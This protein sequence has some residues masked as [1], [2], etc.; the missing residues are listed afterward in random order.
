RKPH[1]PIFQHVVDHAQLKPQETVF[2]EDTPHN[3]EGAKA[4]GINPL[5]HPR[6][7]D[8]TNTIRT[9]L[10]QHNL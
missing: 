9:F 2:I 6:N 4:V 8:I 10:Q 3:L 7:G 1:S 5:L